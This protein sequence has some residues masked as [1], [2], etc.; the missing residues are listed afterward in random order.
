[1]F[2]LSKLTEAYAQNVPQLTREYKVTGF[3]LIALAIAP[4]FVGGYYTTIMTNMLIIILAALGL[5]ILSGYTEYISI[6]HAMFFGIGG[7]TTAYLTLETNLGFIISFLVMVVV[8]VVLSA[9]IGKLTFVTRGI[10]FALLTFAFN[11]FFQNLVINLDF[12]GGPVG[13]TGV[14]AL[15]GTQTSFY[16]LTYG[17]ILAG[18]VGWFYLVHTGIVDVLT[19]IGEDEILAEN[20]GINTHRY[21]LIAFGISGLYTAV[22]GSLYAHNL[23]FVSPSI[24]GFAFSLEFLIVLVLGGVGTFSGVFLGGIVFTV[25]QQLADFAG[26]FSLLATGLLILFVMLFMPGGIAGMFREE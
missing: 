20:L 24:F 9:L 13:L 7:Y 10:Y 8:V 6:G 16:Y 25:I 23:Q 18:I 21:K 26:G 5:N 3:L 22:A 14:P 1:M 12:L 19:T 11:F 2:E 17:F 4:L 15:L